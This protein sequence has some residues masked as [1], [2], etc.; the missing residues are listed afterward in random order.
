VALWLTLLLALVATAAFA[1]TFPK[2]SGF[3]VDAANI[4]PP[5][6]EAALTQRLDQL[7]QATG[8]QFVV[9]TIPDLEGRPI[10]DYGY[11]LGRAWGVG[12]KEADNGAIL[13]VAPND[14]QVRIEV[15][16]GLEPT[17][18]DAV[19]SVIINEQ[20][21]PRFR[22]G[23]IPGGTVAG[24]TA[25]ADLLATPDAERAAKVAAAA[26]EYDRTHKRAA[27][28]SGGGGGAMFGFWGIVALFIL[29]SMLRGRG[30]RGR[31]RRFGGSNLPIVLW[32]IGEAMGHASR[33]GGGGWGGG[34]G[35][36]GGWGGGGFGGGGGGGFG[37]GGSSGSW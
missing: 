26:A 24:A 7:Q 18:T 34:P 37:G 3:V 5:G 4:L 12:L 25:V 27:S 17:L 32:T 10:D 21:L 23:D 35:G 14:R 36:G 28:G 11:R 6:Q 31:G 33:G 22:A 20:I 19:T 13:I 16:Y 9:A 29:L 8:T 2:F 15:G 1:Q 30:K